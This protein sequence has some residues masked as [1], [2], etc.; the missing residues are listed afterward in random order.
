MR[1]Q[2]RATALSAL[3]TPFAGV[4][5]G[6]LFQ[7]ARS[8]SGGQAAASS[9]N[10][11]SLA[12]VSNGVLVVAAA[13]STEANAVMLFCSSLVKVVIIGFLWATLCAVMTW[14]TPMCLKSKAIPR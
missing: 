5:P 6:R 7:M 9:A 1:A 13:S 3:L 11:F 10:S 2:I 14:I 8:R 12:K 4:T